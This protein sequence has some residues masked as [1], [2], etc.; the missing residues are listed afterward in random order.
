MFYDEFLG[1]YNF[2]LK[3]CDLNVNLT[4]RVDFNV[5]DTIKNQ[6]ESK[7]IDQKLVDKN[8]ITEYLADSVNKEIRSNILPN[9]K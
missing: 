4:F 7:V 3:N 9:L 1:S 2:H 8:N 6:G 5:P